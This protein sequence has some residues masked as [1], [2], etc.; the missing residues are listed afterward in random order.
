M[1]RV[2]VVSDGPTVFTDKNQTTRLSCK[3]YSWDQDQTNL[4]DA[5]A[6]RWIRSS[7]NPNSDEIW[8]ANHTGQK[9]ITITHSDIKNNAT[10]HCQVELK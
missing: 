5:S 10:F 9:S 1:Y 4:I 8:N 2:E 7:S 3:V 6:F